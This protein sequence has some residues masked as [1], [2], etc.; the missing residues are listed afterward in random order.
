M[1]GEGWE[2]ESL[3]TTWRAP[4]WSPLTYNGHRSI[5]E[6]ESG[7]NWKSHRVP[8][9][10]WWRQRGSQ[11]VGSRSEGEN[12]FKKKKSWPH[13][14]VGWTV[15]FHSSNCLTSLYLQH[16]SKR[17]GTRFS[18]DIHH[19]TCPAVHVFGS[20]MSAPTVTSGGRKLNFTLRRKSFFDTREIESTPN[21]STPISKSIWLRLVQEGQEEI[22]MQ[23]WTWIKLMEPRRRLYPEETGEKPCRRPW[24]FCGGSQKKIKD[25]HHEQ[26]R[27]GDQAK[28][29][30]ETGAVTDDETNLRKQQCSWAFPLSNLNLNLCCRR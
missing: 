16:H 26:K 7:V 23:D 14:T 21:N 9:K 2:W 5:D 3:V 19:H 6:P 12:L 8:K 24:I 22:N 13:L 10:K 20:A 30:F 17:R 28:P 15:T 27:V 4:K 29:T 11:D 25:R 1:N 18:F